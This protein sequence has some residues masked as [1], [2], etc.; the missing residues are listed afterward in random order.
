ME[1]A[2]I[3]HLLQELQQEGEQLL[4][5]DGRLRK[6]VGFVLL[7]QA[8]GSGREPK[9][10]G[11]PGGYLMLPDAQA[12]EIPLPDPQGGSA[13]HPFAPSS[14]HSLVGLQLLHDAPEVE[15]RQVLQ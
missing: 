13:H 4:C 7:V 15:D 6:N 5:Q 1:W 12:S 11:S 8:G 14:V 10:K 2:G 3:G 9:H